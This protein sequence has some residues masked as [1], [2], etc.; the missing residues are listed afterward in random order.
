MLK[1]R[2][3]PVGGMKVTETSI[4]MMPGESGRDISDRDKDNISEMLANMS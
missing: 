4:E 1:E 2:N 3:I